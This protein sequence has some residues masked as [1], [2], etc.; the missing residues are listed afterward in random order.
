MVETFTRFDAAD[1]LE[2]TADQEAF[3]EASAEG[4]NVASMAAAFITVARA[5]NR[6]ASNQTAR[7]QKVTLTR[8]EITTALAAKGLPYFATIA[9]VAR[10][11]GL[12]MRF[13]S[14][15]ATSRR[16]RLKP[17]SR[18]TIRR[19]RSMETRQVTRHYRQAA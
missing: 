6:V 9:R 3:L 5:Q 4:G 10:A 13:R 2:T 14:I 1:F 8:D 12:E 17:I 16:P 11:M 19:L 15:A 18:H 7:G